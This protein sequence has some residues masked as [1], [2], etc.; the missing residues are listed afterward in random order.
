MKL[1]YKLFILLGAV[2][3]A[4]VL[5]MIFQSGPSYD[6]EKVHPRLGNLQQ[7]YH[8]VKTYYWADGGSIGIE[9]VGRNGH[10]EQFTV[11]AKLGDDNPYTRVYVGALNDSFPD[12]VEVSEPEDTRRMLT[13]VLSDYP[14]RTPYDD[15][16]LMSLRG[17]P[18]DYVRCFYHWWCGHYDGSGIYIY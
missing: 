6:R 14:D 1:R 12:A 13:R 16:N 7:P 11:R 18:K 15:S 2:V 5:Y 17:Y 10:Q 4:G 3:L 9:I 8:K